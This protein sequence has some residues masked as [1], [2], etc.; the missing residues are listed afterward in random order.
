MVGIVYID[1]VGKSFPG[2]RE[3]AIR[4]ENGSGHKNPVILP[5]E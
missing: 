4:R 3:W 5:P 1:I 2:P